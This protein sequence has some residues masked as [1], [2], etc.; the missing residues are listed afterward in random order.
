MT[1]I[2]DTIDPNCIDSDREINEHIDKKSVLRSDIN[3]F[4]EN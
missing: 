3:E 1:F 4:R 2:S